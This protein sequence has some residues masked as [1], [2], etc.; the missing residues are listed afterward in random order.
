MGKI[1]PV[2]HGHAAVKSLLKAFW[3]AQGTLLV[4]FLANGARMNAYCYRTTFDHLKEAI[5]MKSPALLTDKV[6]LLHDSSHSTTSHFT[7]QLMEL[8]QFC[9]EPSNFHFFEP[10]KKISSESNFNMMM[11]ER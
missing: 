7:V 3:D 2:V 1:F 10:T 6:A 11:G 5:W 9:L 4:E 8:L